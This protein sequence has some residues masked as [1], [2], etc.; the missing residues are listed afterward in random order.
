MC[1]THA[2]VEG[3]QVTDKD[4]NGM[5]TT[6][7]DYEQLTEDGHNFFLI[8]NV[9]NYSDVRLTVCPGGGIAR[10]RIYENDGNRIVHCSDLE[11]RDKPNVPLDNGALVK[12]ETPRKVNT[13]V[14]D[15]HNSQPAASQSCIP[16]EIPLTSPTV[17][18]FISIPD[19]DLYEE[20]VMEESFLVLA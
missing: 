10:F 16:H 12:K 11:S 7:T 3:Y 8:H 20:S 4:T 2:L 13:S 6:L 5:W 14:H 15:T 1:P 19:P 18:G 9:D 17:E